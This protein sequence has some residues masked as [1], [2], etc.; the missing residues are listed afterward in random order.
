MRHEIDQLRSQVDEYKR[1]IVLWEQKL[2]SLQ[3]PPTIPPGATPKQISEIYAQSGNREDQL[4]A[5][6]AA[7]VELKHRLGLLIAE[8]EH[9]QKERQHQRQKEHSDQIT[10]TVLAKLNR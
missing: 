6:E 5:A 2:V 4:V 7:L 10:A 1:T 3:T 9:C 8:L